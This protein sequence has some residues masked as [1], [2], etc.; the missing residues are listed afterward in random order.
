MENALY[1]QWLEKAADEDILAELRSIA[2]D[3]EA[4]S[5]RFYRALEFGTGGLRGVI[6]A[7]TNRMNI[8]TVGL[9]AQALADYLKASDGTL[10]VAIGHDSR[11][12]S[13]EFA[14]AAAA[15][16]ASN[17]VKVH[18]F[19]ELEP[20]PVVSYAVRTL[21]CGAGIMIT[22][23][24]NPAK[25]N[26]FKCY[27]ADGCQMT[28]KAAGEVYDF[29]RRLDIFADLKFGDFEELVA[30]G[31]IEYISD[32]LLESYIDV[33]QSRSVNPGVCE[34]ADLSVIYT[35]LCGTGNKP[36]RAIL[37]RIGVKNVTVESRQENPDGNFPGCPYP[38]PEIREAFT[39]SLEL[40]QQL[41]PELLLATDPDADRVGIAVR[42]E[43][44]YVLMSG[45]E[46]G[47]LLTDYILSSLKA[48]GKLPANP[49]VIKTIVTSDL[50]AR[51]ALSYGC[52]VRN[53]LTGF[54]YIGE[55]IG[56]LEKA[57]EVDRFIFG[58]EESYGYLSGSYARD[59]DA[60]VASM[61]ICEM[62]SYYKL[63]GKTLLDVM[64]ELYE[65]YGY[66]C[67][68]LC[69]FQFEGQEG[70]L[71]MKSIMNNL[72]ENAPTE[73]GGE[74]VAISRD[75]EQH[76][77]RNLETGETAEITLPT[78]NVLAY[79]FK[80]GG[81]VIVRPSGTEPKLKVYLT[82]VAA[83]NEAGAQCLNTLEASVK[84][85]VE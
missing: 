62:A 76:I 51:I 75:Y 68:R 48:Q 21:G 61:L 29:M 60:V 59:K 20:T 42:S 74:V 19:T 23:S 43:D 15:V 47:A 24:H 30:A 5:D 78:S 28:D 54:K 10:A 66:Y 72:R 82:A 12:K 58:Y 35:P 3:E 14:K 41:N 57:G 44:G 39:Y 79:I 63:Q 73:I 8:Y 83:S 27:G 84:S 67:H 81:S 6:G 37:E 18:I 56:L 45:N 38:N 16:L 77:E 2:G 50:G 53:L 65:K 13:R 36:V 4:I 52:E 85:L 26:G 25:Y 64:H 32:S 80:D 49:V 31:A 9:A 55:Q 34:K 46:V 7:G 17:G 40:A 69:N 1:A 22:A 70:M 71:K 11:I 33:V